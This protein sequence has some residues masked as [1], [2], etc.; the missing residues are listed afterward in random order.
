M[1]QTSIAI[2]PDIIYTQVDLMLRSTEPDNHTFT[3]TLEAT[4][5]VDSVA[6]QMFLPQ[7]RPSALKMLSHKDI[8]YLAWAIHPSSH[9]PQCI[10]PT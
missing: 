1:F 2:T 7:L 5:P 10:L 3:L 8:L 9:S 6:L 4:E